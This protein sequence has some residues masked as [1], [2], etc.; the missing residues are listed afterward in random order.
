MPAVVAGLLVSIFLTR[1]LG[2]KTA[3]IVGA[4]TGTALHMIILLT[5]RAKE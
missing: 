2:W 5:A 1:W 3:F 4:C